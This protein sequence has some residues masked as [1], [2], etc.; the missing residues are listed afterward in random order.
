MGRGPFVAGRPRVPALWP[1]GP[2]HQAEGQEHPDRRLQVQGLPQALHREGRHHLRGQPHP[3]CGCGCRRSRCCAPARRASAA[4]SCTA[5]WASPSS[6]RGSCRIAS[7]RPCAL[8]GSCRRWAALAASSRSTRPSTAAPQPIPRA[9]GART[10]RSPIRRTRTSFCRWWSA[11]ASVRS[12]HVAGSTVSQVIP[13][14]EHNVSREA[15]V[16]T[17]TAQLYRYR[18]G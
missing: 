2:H 14:V 8:A 17:D 18:L 4:T 10:A 13:I 1:T 9:A 5:C 11:A 12:Y 6:R 3:A 16:M 15:A 7:A